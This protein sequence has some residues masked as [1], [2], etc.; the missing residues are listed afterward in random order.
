MEIERFDLENGWQ[1]Y[2][3]TVYSGHWRYLEMSSVIIRHYRLEEYSLYTNLELILFY[4][5]ITFSLL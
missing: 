3:L 5:L 1:T 4:K 2:S